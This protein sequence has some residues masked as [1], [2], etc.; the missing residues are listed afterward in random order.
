MPFKYDS[1]PLKKVLNWILVEGSIYFKSNRAWGWPTHAQIEPTSFC[2]LKCALCPVTEGLKRSSH[3]MRFS[4]FK[5]FIDEISDYLLLIILWDW[6]EPFLN[7][8]VYKMISYA[9]DKNIKIVSSSNGHIFAKGDAAEQVVKSGLDYLIFAVDGTSQKTYER[10]RK[11]GKLKTVKKGIRNIVMA[12][13]KLQSKSPLLNLRF[14]AMKHNEQEI[15]DLQEFGRQLGVDFV[16]VKTLNPHNDGKI[17][18]NEEYG[19]E[20]IPENP[21]YRRFKYDLKKHSRIR[22]KNIPCKSLWNCPAIHSNGAVCTCTFDVNANYVMGDIKQESFRRIWRNHNYR[23]IRA[24]FRNN[25][26]AIPICSGC[27]FAFEGG[28]MSTET[29]V[30]THFISSSG[31]KT[32]RCK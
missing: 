2:N 32:V 13:Q 3:H 27:T 11:G 18:G 20:F 6:G 4:T 30:Q 17:I 29:I 19:N 23:S 28:S 12:K 31:D 24:N 22:R 15:H 8:D 21:D 5:K 9:K 16:T 7:P 10:Y 26:Q 14:I 25:Y 1:V